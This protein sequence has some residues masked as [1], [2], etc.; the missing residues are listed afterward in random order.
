M[1]P[2][3]MRGQTYFFNPEDQTAFMKQKLKETERRESIWSAEVRRGSGDSNDLMS[4]SR[5]ERRHHRRVVAQPVVA[6]G[7]R[8]RQNRHP[9]R[10]A[11]A[12]PGGP[13][14]APAVS[15]LD[16]HLLHSLRSTLY[17]WD[18]T[19]L[20]GAAVDHHMLPRRLAP[21]G[22]WRAWIVWAKLHKLHNYPPM[23]TTPGFAS[24]SL[25]EGCSKPYQLVLASGAARLTETAP[26]SP[27]IQSNLYPHG[28]FRMSSHPEEPE[29][30]LAIR[31]CARM[32]GPLAG[33]VT[34]ERPRSL[35]LAP[36]LAVGF[37]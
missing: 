7:V 11:P 20:E 30:R 32:G 28:R 24:P 25:D 36:G 1:V 37:L 5:Q 35:S 16:F 13:P 33:E 3:Q 26:R 15:S 18:R 12:S 10:S 23:L 8:N 2:G 31:K 21:P 22:A 14:D 19:E 34:S 4:A 9:G 6:L 27:V 29:A 17:A